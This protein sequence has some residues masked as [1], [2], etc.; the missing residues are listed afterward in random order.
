MTTYKNIDARRAETPEERRQRLADPALDNA[1]EDRRAIQDSNLTLQQGIAAARKQEFENRKL[2]LDSDIIGLRRMTDRAARGYVKAS[3]DAYCRI[4]ERVER[5]AQIMADEFGHGVDIPAFDPPT[6]GRSGNTR[7]V[8]PRSVAARVQDSFYRETGG[9]G[10]SGRAGP[11]PG[12]PGSDAN[13]AWLNFQ[14][15]AK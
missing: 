5:L 12:V 15:G 3:R 2:Q 9:K 1:V 14:G 4:Y 13:T 7:T 11:E 10:P 6:D 8:E